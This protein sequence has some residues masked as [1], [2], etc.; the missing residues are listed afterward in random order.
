MIIP[1]KGTFTSVFKDKKVIKKS[2]NRRNQGFSS[3]FMLVDERIRIL[4]RIRTH[5]LR[6]RIQEA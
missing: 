4:S 1:F 6:I 3:F 5:K 2:Q